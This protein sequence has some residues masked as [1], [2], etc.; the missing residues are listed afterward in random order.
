MEL[1][2]DPNPFLTLR[3]AQLPESETS[4]RDSKKNYRY[5]LQYHSIKV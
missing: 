4:G 3:N 2:R 1:L 5:L